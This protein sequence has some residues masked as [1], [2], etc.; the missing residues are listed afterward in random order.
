[1]KLHKLLLPRAV[2]RWLVTPPPH[3]PASYL[4]FYSLSNSTH[5]LGLLAHTIFLIVFTSIGVKLLAWFNLFSVILFC[6]TLWASKRG[7]L[8]TA[9]LIGGLEV[10][11]HQGL[12]VLAVGLAPAFH[13]YV[14]IL[15]IG[16]LFYQ[17][18]PVKLRIAMAIL[19]VIDYIAIYL[20]GLR[21]TPWYQL[22]TAV[23]YGLA[24]VNV[25]IF[26]ATVMILCIYFQYSVQNA[27]RHAERMAQ[28][29]TLFLANMSHELRTPLN[30]ILGFAQ[31]LQRSTGLT[32]QDK[33][34]LSTI[35]RSG[36]HL[37]RLIN[38]ILDMSKLEQGKFTLQRNAFDLL[39]MIGELHAMF[40]LAARQKQVELHFDLAPDLPRHLRGDELRLRQI[41]IN[42]LSNALKFTAKGQV[43]LSV[44]VISG[45]ST[46]E[47]RL[48]FKV[49]DTGGGIA[50]AEQGELF[51]LF[52]QTTT[53]LESRKGTGLGLALSKRF[54]ELMGGH[55]GV[56]SEEGCG[57]TFW[58][59]V[60]AELVLAVE[61]RPTVDCRK[62][63]GT[64]IKGDERPVMLVVDDNAQNRDLLTQVLSHL[65]FHVEAATD[66]AE[67]V[68]EWERLD[69][70]MIW[71]DL[72]MP[73]IDGNE[74]TRIIRQRAEEAGRPSP[75]IVAIT[76]SVLDTEASAKKHVRFDA[77]VNKPFH[78]TRIHEVLGQLLDLEFTYV[79]PISPAANSEAAAKIDPRTRLDLLDPAFAKELADASMLADFERAQRIIQ[80][81][82]EADAPLGSHLTELLDGYRFD[83]LQDLTKPVAATQASTS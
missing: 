6:F 81:I 61:E 63:T 53:G 74:A 37:L 7:W 9:L 78:E 12:A 21:L 18:I 42:L 46:N 24:T 16:V 15:A 34:N 72:R 73:V 19:P 45:L 60:P 50:K 20:V 59:E 17:H 23:T 47:P 65:G 82:T 51:K 83:L 25:T 76:A 52:T 13:H 28:A 33:A 55:M 1:V 68:A 39:N 27:R 49:E 35:N 75:K 14:L 58:F 26:V 62:I 29:K 41:L 4:D 43:H 31:I 30:A 36:E 48:I 32:D 44:R 3:L 67:A 66:G 5:A 11:T 40:S 70:A 54:V 2:H 22:S 10:G 77:H 69:P 8:N 56:E 57:S 38:D 71:M 64:V 79:D 80:K